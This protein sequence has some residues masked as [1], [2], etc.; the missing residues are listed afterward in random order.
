M[1]RL[2]A[3]AIVLVAVIGVEGTNVA[4]VLTPALLLG[5]P[6]LFKRYVGERV[7]RR[8]TRRA[9][10]LRAACSLTLPRAPR[11][12]GARAAALAVP[13]SGRA[14]PLPALL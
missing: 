12:L 9:I 7:I 1:L 10:V 11:S 4:L 3:I 13:G 8:L 6:L 2:L 14:P 5:L